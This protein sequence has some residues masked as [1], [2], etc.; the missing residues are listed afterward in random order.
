MF[1]ILLFYLISSLTLYFGF[2]YYNKNP[3]YFDFWT[4]AFL[5]LYTFPWLILFSKK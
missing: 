3:K 5:G 4:Y 2:I 1:F